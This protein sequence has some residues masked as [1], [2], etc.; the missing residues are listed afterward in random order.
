MYK[1]IKIPWRLVGTKKNK[2]LHFRCDQYVK[3]VYF[4]V[5]NI[6]KCMRAKNHTF[7][8]DTNTNCN[9]IIGSR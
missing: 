4:R 8:T 9:E 3:I 1:S 7:D 2:G 5:Y 6:Q